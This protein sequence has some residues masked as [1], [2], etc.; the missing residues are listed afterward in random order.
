MKKV[1][2]MAKGMVKKAKKTTWKKV[3]ELQFSVMNIFHLTRIYTNF[4]NLHW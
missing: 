1:K 2:D 3:K 4:L